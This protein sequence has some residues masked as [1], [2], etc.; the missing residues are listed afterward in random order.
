M[1]KDQSPNGWSFVFSGLK[2]PA[3]SA[4]LTINIQ[5]PSIALNL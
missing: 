2:L 4:S 5:L 1:P 3:L